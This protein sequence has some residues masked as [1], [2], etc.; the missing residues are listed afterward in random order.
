M[1]NLVNML[2]I[3]AS[4]LILTS[5]R[6]KKAAEEKAEQ[7]SDW[8]RHLS[9]HRYPKYQDSGVEEG[10]VVLSVQRSALVTGSAIRGDGDGRFSVFRTCQGA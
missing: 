8:R 4:I 1:K 6:N 10:D 9:F 5:C 7:R 3:V 2:L